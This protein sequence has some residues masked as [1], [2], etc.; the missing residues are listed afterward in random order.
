MNL[1]EVLILLGSPNSPDGK[2]G[3][4]ALDRVKY[5][6]ELFQQ[7]KRPILC[8]GGFGSHFNTSPWPHAFL[9]QQELMKLGVP[10]DS[11]LPLAISSNTVDD[12]VQSKKVLEEFSVH[13]L[14]IIT[15]Q[16]HVERVRLIFD[17]I[18][19]SY[20]KQ[21]DGVEHL[22]FIPELEQL[23]VHEARAIHEIKK[24]GLYY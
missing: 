6:N 8:T 1:Q 12:A 22:S 21:F 23:K 5:V 13:L 19:S 3:P 4:I 17:E 10:E 9:L 2:L 20:S 15:S 14:R 7:E 18:L 24:N 16:Y 11:F